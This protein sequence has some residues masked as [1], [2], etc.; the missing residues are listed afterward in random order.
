MRDHETLLHE[1]IDTYRSRGIILD[2]FQIDACR[3]LGTGKDVLVSAPTGSGKTVVAHYAVEL[4]LATEKRCVYTA[5]IKALSNQ[6]YNEL[7]ARLGGE[8]VGLLT[9][10]LTINRDA[11]ILVVTTEVLRNMLFQNSPDIP[12]VGYVVLDEVH[13]LADRERGPVWEEVILSL[14]PH[15]RLVSLSATVAN[16]EE[17]VSWMRSVRGA[18]ELIVSDV[19]PVPLEQHVA[20]GRK[21]YPLYGQKGDPDSSLLNA[22]NRQENSPRERARRLSDADRRRIIGILERRD[23]LPAIEFIFSR[24]G[25]DLAAMAL[26]RHDVWLTSPAEQKEIRRYV[27]SVRESLSESD[28]RAVRFESIANCLL[29]G[30][31]VHHAGILPA[32]KSLTEK[33]MEMG[34][35]RIVYAT[36][37]L[38]LGID[39]PVRSVV[40]E[41]LRRWNGQGFIDLTATE[42]TQ[43]IG[44]AGR[45]GKDTVGH[46]VVVGNQDLDVWALADLGS[47]RVEPLLSA[48]QP[49][50]NTVV[51]LLAE[52]SYPDARELMGASFAQYQRN[53]DLG[54]IEARSQRVRRRIADEEERLTCERGDLV[55]YLRMRSKSGRAAKSARKAAKRIYRQRI[56]ESFQDARTGILY[57]YARG[58]ELEYGVVLSSDP[59]RLRVINWYGEVSWI[60]EDDLSSELRELDAFQLPQGRS[61]RDR[62]TREQIADGILDEV[63]ERLELG[64]DRDLL[65]SWSRFAEPRDQEFA[66]HPC[67]DCPDIEQH[68]RDGE[69]LLSLD[70][71]LAELRETAA[72]FTDSVG[73]EFDRTADVLLELGILQRAAA[74]YEGAESSD[75]GEAPP[76]VVEGVRLGGGANVLRHLHLENDLLLYECLSQLQEGE[77]DAAAMAGWASMFLGDDRLGT[78]QPTWGSLP[79]L[80]RRARKSA[81]YL[82]GLELRHEIARTGEVTPGCADVFAAWCSGATLEDCLTMARMVAGDFVTAARRVIDLLGQ[83]VVAGEGTWISDVARQAREKMR[84]SELL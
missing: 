30:F 13:Y 10:D 38:A 50:Y 34:L 54:G 16:T 37:T 2:P 44:R 23:M 47:G 14:P 12:D 57:A 20:V 69:T 52:R 31:G 8:T 79:N 73:R 48:F 75:D 55:Q 11:P 56:A 43:L 35:L 49:S 62:D 82:Q 33:L 36:G 28:R 83:I 4:A 9:G 59:R 26:Q 63:D 61:I 51:N 65:D 19:R 29:R 1:Y 17:F 71:R 21:L 6:K 32:L 60:R 84:R 64:I 67:N 41:D 15:I 72:S 66:A 18:T 5:P 39:M 68:L 27:A 42:Y 3:A 77:L 78:H 74:E 24:K 46:A 53:A 40:V 70:N 22:M 45:R 25:C 58:G 7:A 80:V 76:P 81:E